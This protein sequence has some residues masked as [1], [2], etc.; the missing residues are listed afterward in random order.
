[1]INMDELFEEIRDDEGVRNFKYLCSENHPTI[2]VGHRVR[3]ADPEAGLEV[4]DA[5]AHPLDL[6]AAQTIS[7]DRVRELFEEDVSVCIEACQK[8]Y[9]NWDQLPQDAQHVLAN[10]SFQLG[11][12]TLRK[13]VNMNKAVDDQ[14]WSAVA[15]Q[16]LDSRWA[17]QTPARCERLRARIKKLL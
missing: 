10:M 17:Q 1:M 3:D 11:E 13:F 15:W 12:G 5:D 4:F 16:M 2:G 8:I 7:E 9:A 14:D 6:D